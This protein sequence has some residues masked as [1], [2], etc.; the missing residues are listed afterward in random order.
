[1]T[2]ILKLINGV[3][4]LTATA[5]LILVLSY[6]LPSNLQLPLFFVHAGQES[7]ATQNDT[8]KIIV[9]TTISNKAQEMLKN[10]HNEHPNFFCNPCAR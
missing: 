2:K 1:M 3:I 10:Y 4:G 7:T 5:T 8:S 9:P 6:L